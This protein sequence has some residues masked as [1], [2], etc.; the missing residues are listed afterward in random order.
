MVKSRCR[1]C[2]Y[3]EPDDMKDQLG[4]CHRHAPVPSIDDECRLVPNRIA[5][6]A[7][8]P[9]DWCGHFEAH[10]S[11]QTSHVCHHKAAS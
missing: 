6:P 8:W 11:Y 3:F 10:S 1:D 5:W 2:Q 7:V 4:T 9:K